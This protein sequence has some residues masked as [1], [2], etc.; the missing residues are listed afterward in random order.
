[1]NHS[2]EL[3]LKAILFLGIAIP[4]LLFYGWTA[5]FGWRAWRALRS[6]RTWRGLALAVVA[7]MPP[8]WYGAEYVAAILRQE[9][10]KQAVRDGEALPRLATVPRTLVVHGGRAPSWQDALVEMGAFDEIYVTGN[11]PSLRIAN[12]RQPGCDRFA[13]GSSHS[14]NIFR[15]RTGFLVCA[16]ATAVERVPSDGLHFNLLAPGHPRDSRD[17]RSYY[18]LTFI[19]GGTTQRIGFT[20][21]PQ[22]NVPVLPPVLWPLGIAKNERT[23]QHVAP[24]HGE[25]PFLFGR[26]GFDPG[27]LNPAAQPSAEEVRAEYL[28]LRDSAERADQV[29]AGYIATAVGGAALSAADVEPILETNAIDTDFG[30][31]IGYQQF[32]TH[33]NRLCDFPEMLVAACKSKRAHI[34]ASVP[35]RAAALA[36]CE[37]L[38]GQCDW[39]RSAK[40][41]QP[42][43]DGQVA[44]CSQ[45]QTAARDEEL[46]PLREN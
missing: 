8:A 26:L 15:A 30:R 10:L 42:M 23:L 31:E 21:T 7:L 43:V 25:M 34:P 9:R 16:A 3:F 29:V 1:M 4:T 33:I 2:V 6:D 37:R 46:R 11:G 36:R 27:R 44:S 12:A 39:C 40:L 41:C 28:R 22:V 32:C 20:G 38:P 45:E 24:W 17:W 14:Q 5:F 19:D 18:E 13:R 35:Y